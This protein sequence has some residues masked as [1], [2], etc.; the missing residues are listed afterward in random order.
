MGRVSQA[1]AQENRKRT[2]ETAARL[3]RE[4]G[5]GRVSVAD[6][7][8]AVGLTPGG[9]YKQFTS[10]HALVTEAVGSAFAQQAQRLAD[11]GDTRTAFIASYLSPAHRDE[12]GTGC[13]SAGFGSD[14]AHGRSEER[15]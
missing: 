3:F 9:F 8:A 10:K 15:R 11:A 5:V 13:P 7:M 4:R 1:Q 14:L 6:V 2:V 12:P